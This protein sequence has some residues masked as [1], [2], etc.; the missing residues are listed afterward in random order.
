MSTLKKQ[1]NLKKNKESF[2]NKID[3]ISLYEEEVFLLLF[4]DFLNF[5]VDFYTGHF[6]PNSRVFDI[7]LKNQDYETQF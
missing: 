1:K 7:P 6:C 5:V 2:T 4:C 3:V